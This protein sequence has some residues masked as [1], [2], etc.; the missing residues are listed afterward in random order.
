MPPPQVQARV[1]GATA[2]SSKAVTYC[3]PLTMMRAGHLSARLCKGLQGKSRQVF[4]P[5]D[6]H[7][8]KYEPRQLRRGSHF[9]MDRSILLWLRRNYCPALHHSDLDRPLSVCSG[10]DRVINEQVCSGVSLTCVPPG[11]T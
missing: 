5:T 10:D 4:G 2:P 1:G 7:H 3:R 6:R 11:T 8:Q 9:W